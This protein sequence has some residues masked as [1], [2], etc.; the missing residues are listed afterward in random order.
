VVLYEMLCGR[1]PFEA[2]TAIALMLAHIREEPLPPSQRTSGQAIPRALDA[3]VMRALAK[4]PGDR[5]ESAP[6]MASA[7]SAALQGHALGADETTRS[8]PAYAVGPEA[9]PAVAQ[10]VPLAP[11]RSSRRLGLVPIGLILLLVVGGALTGGVMLLAREDE[12]DPDRNLAAVADTPEDETP[13]VTATATS[14]I[15]P[16]ATASAEAAVLATRE[17]ERLAAE[18]TQTPTDPPPTPTETLEPTP[19]ETLA[20]TPTETLEPTPTVTLEPTPTEPPVEDPTSPLIQQNGS[21]GQEESTEETTTEEAAAIQGAGAQTY[22][23][24]ITAADWNGAYY[25]EVGNLQPWS[26]LYSQATQYHTGSIFFDLPGEPVDDTFQLTVEGMTSENF[27][28][29]PLAIEINGVNVATMNTPFPTW[30]GQ[31]GAQPWAEATF[32]LPTEPL[33]AG[34]NEISIIN[35]MESGEYG[36]P[37]YVLLADATL[38]IEVAATSGAAGD[39][40][41]SSSDESAAVQFNAANEDDN[42]GPDNSGHRGSGDG[43]GNGRDDDKE[44]KRENDDKEKDED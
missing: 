36:L 22:T 38:T 35:L 19:T 7:L 18:P 40:A 37:P 30:N 1:L 8:L 33:Q 20:P 28:E 17:A 11:Q 27:T 42:S 13:T 6:A 15:D 29:V 25:R 44:D 31:E 9:R 2:P 34:R 10:E 5:F 41:V 4:D 3:V 21:A 26:A 43:N 32:S 24:S 39:L 12:P 14:E 23:G 16:T